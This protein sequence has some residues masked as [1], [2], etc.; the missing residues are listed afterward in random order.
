M[1]I[2]NVIR[3][4]NYHHIGAET[5]FI[6]GG[7]PPLRGKTMR[8]K[9]EYMMN[10]YDHIRKSVMRAPRG[11]RDMFGGV[12]T[13]PVSDNAHCGVFYMGAITDNTYYPMCGGGTVALATMLVNTGKV[14]ACEPITEVIIDTALGQVKCKATIKDGKAVEITFTNV[15]A[16]IHTRG[17]EIET[18]AFG[19][20]KV[21]IGYGGGSFCVFVDMDKINCKLKREKINNMIAPALEIMTKAN[22]KVK[23]VHP[24][25]EDIKDIDSCMYCDYIGDVGRELLVLGDEMIGRCPSGTGTAARMIL[26]YEKGKIEFG[27]EFIQKSMIDTSLKGKLVKET[28]IGNYKA[29]IAEITSSAYLTGIHEFFI[30]DDD[31]LKE[32]YVL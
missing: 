31:P 15:P 29:F 14:A 6:T 24:E 3:T 16:F 28:K 4:V 9:M 26:E 23:C 13:E 25:N 1:K 18:D 10:N 19:K 2:N 8:E 27:E 30:E 17:L 11:N 21:D 20:F 7:V 5:C 32:G 22:N 12:I